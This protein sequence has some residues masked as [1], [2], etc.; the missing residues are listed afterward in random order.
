MSIVGPRPTIPVQVE[1][2]DERQRGRLAVAPGHHRLGA[3]QRAR[4]AALVASASSSTSGTS[5]TARS[6]L[7]LRILARTAAIL[8]RGQGLYKG[9][10]GG[11][12]R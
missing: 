8:L 10:T 2:Y 11:W 7:D 12:G 5:S 3:G 6:R 4:L 9:D 1:Q